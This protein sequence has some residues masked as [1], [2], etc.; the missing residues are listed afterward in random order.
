[1]NNKS[2]FFVVYPRLNQSATDKIMHDISF[3]LGF[4]YNL[5]SYAEVQDEEQYYT[6]VVA[7]AIEEADFVLILPSLPR[8]VET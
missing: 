4:D 7:P 6:D 8:C 3:Q 2:N 5:W 1:M